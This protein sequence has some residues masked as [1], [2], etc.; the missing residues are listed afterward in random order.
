[1]VFL[2]IFAGL[3]GLAARNSTRGQAMVR[4]RFR[5]RTL[6]TGPEGQGDMT[7]WLRYQ[8]HKV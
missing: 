4:L 6:R 1:M 2:K 3:G 7:S 5:E 8:L